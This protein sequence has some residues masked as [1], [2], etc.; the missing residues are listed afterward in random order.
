M[1]DW[2]DSM[3]ARDR[4]DSIA[5]TI[6]QP[7]SVNWIK[8]QAEAGSWET[9]KSELD[10]LVESGQLTTV[11]VD[12]ETRYAVDGMRAYLDH[13]Q[14]L[15]VEHSKA[16]LRDELEAIAEE[17]AAWKETY[18]VDSRDELEATIASALPPEEVRERR[19]VV[20]DWEENDGYRER[21]Q[22]ALRLYDDLS[23]QAAATVGDAHGHA[24]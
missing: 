12:G 20:R 8:E 19:Q 14:A 16:E 22:H 17:I 7:R 2:T 18:D 6:S 10:R 5:L 1:D 24:D 21:I 4:I 9:T 11:T 23:T 13:V 3:T 15:V